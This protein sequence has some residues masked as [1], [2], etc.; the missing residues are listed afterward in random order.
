V[1]G[2][3]GELGAIRGFLDELT[4]GFQGLVLEG[5]A[6]IGK[7]VLWEAATAEA[8]SRGFLV[9]VARPVEAETSLSYSGLTDL[10]A[11][12]E[13]DVFE[14]LP[15]PQR[16]AL[17]VALLRSGPGGAAP[18]QRA[19]FTAITAILRRLA[20]S[21]PVVVA[22]DD[23]PWL[24][25]PS[26]GA[27]AFAARRLG[28]D[29]VGLIGAVRSGR[30]DGIER[31]PETL[32]GEQFTRLRVGPLGLAAIHHVI[33]ERLGESPP[34]PM[35]LRV[36][37]ASG[38]NPLFALELARRLE[39]IAPA[40]GEALAVPDDLRAL[41]EARL[42][43]LPA[44]TRAALLTV[45]AI[46]QPTSAEL[47][48]PEALRAAEHAGIVVTD[49]PRVRFSHPLYASAI[50]LSVPRV[51]RRR[52]HRRIAGL[53]ADPEERARHLSLATE[54]ADGEVAAALDE[55]AALA[56][57][58]GAPDVAAEL[59]ERARSLTPADRPDEARQRA[60]RAA[61]HSFHAGD[62]RG[63]RR[64][65]EQLLEELPPGPSRVPSLHLLAEA[66]HRDSGPEPAIAYL[67]EA[68]EEARGDAALLAPTELYLAFTLQSTGRFEELREPAERAVAHAE[69]AGDE[70]LLAEALAVSAVGGFLL[71]EG[72]HEGK[73]ARALELEDQD[74]A[75]PIE[76]R[77]TLIAGLLFLY[78][79]DFDRARPLLERL[80]AR[81]VERGEE[82]EL[83]MLLGNLAWLE[84]WAGRLDAA[85]A[86]A[87]QSLELAEQTGAETVRMMSLALRSVAEAHAGKVE[88]TRVVAGEALALA[89]RTGWRVGSF[90]PLYS[91]AF[92]ELS[93][94][95]PKAAASALA[96]LIALVEA[97]GVVEPIRAFFV[98]EA[99]EALAATGEIERAERLAVAFEERSREL[100]RPWAIATGARCRAVAL[101]ARGDVG[102]AVEALERALAAHEQAP[103][104]VEL[105]RTLL[106]KG[107][108]HRRRHETRAAREALERALAICEG[109]G[110][111]LWADRV[112]EDLGRVAPRR[113][114]GELSETEERIAELAASGLTNRKIAEQLFL[115]TKTI[116][117]NLARAYR[118][119]GI[120]SRAELGA[121]LAERTRV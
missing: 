92:L 120:H 39:E 105:A 83:P 117:A 36:H 15:P 46:S 97:Q 17:D 3:D 94:G 103:R 113:V 109:V 88:A 9:L 29:A 51:D 35:L 21:A 65:L 79:G 90:W 11:D 91:V 63:A 69:A 60:F 78:T 20:E 106:V 111:T 115:S 6:G 112:R 18:D 33:K 22:V 54:G 64:I 13:A 56:R 27:L 98:P 76:M 107:R 59:Q 86:F 99:A 72:F 93:L 101:A 77:P 75:V 104:P 8:R 52:L 23:L 116:E 71:G 82:T 68:C 87:E 53:V 30:G 57:S 40:P 44:R 32:S 43:K 119:L 16:A 121:R 19:V 102:G 67:R 80:R 95:D 58:R 45:A 85:S 48:E 14:A 84:S 50:Y 31:L 5:E 4:S 66:V 41:V 108:L 73:I 55:A 118:K 114:E 62:F 70:A 89:E 10:L 74:R 96:P 47:V 12:V 25:G 110:A 42:R 7:T 61:E 81:M 49:G 28:G 38:G 37:R 2:R 34:R 100:G 1:I 26:A 24:D